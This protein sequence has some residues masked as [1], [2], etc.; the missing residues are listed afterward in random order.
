MIDDD[1]KETIFTCEGC[2]S[3]IALMLTLAAGW[4]R[5]QSGDEGTEDDHFHGWHCKPCRDAGRP[6]R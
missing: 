2:G 3:T 4:E 5:D 1:E 6:F